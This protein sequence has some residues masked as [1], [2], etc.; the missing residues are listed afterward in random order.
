MSMKLVKGVLYGEGEHHEKPKQTHI[1]IIG[2]GLTRLL[3]AQGLRKLNARLEAEGQS[4]PFTFSIHERDESSF[5]RGGG[6]SLNIHWALQQLYDILPEELSARIFD[7][8]GSFTFLNLQTG[9]PALKTTIPPGWKGARMSRVRFLQ[10]LMTNLDIHYSHRLSQIT[11]PTD[12]TVRAHIE[13]GDQETGYLLIG[14]D[15]TNSVVRRFVYGAENSKNTQL[16]IRMLNCRS[17]Y[18]LEEL[19]ACLRVDPHLFHA[20][21]PCKMAILCSLFWICRRRGRRTETPSDPPPELPEQLAWLKHMAKHWANPV[22]DLIY[23]MPDDSIVQVI[24]VQEWMPNDANRRPTDGRITTVGDAAHL[25]TSFRGENANHG[26][27]D[28]AQLLALLAPSGNKP[29]D[30]KEV[31]STYEKE[32]VQRSRPPTVKAQEACLDANH[33]SKITSDSPFLS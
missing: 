27:V 23:G 14:A 30:L 7:Q 21:I 20:G 28:V 9:E 22:H 26:V 5:Y 1:I 25:M 29:T 11:F 31:A 13:N 3:L 12:D 15:G 33:Y 17:E 4:A 8:M 24:R 2:A 18:P 32:M 10:L 19:K 16:P 6:F